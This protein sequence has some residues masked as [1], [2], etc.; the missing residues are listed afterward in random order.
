MA[1]Y[2]RNVVSLCGLKLSSIG[3]A[4]FMFSGGLYEY[5]A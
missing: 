3:F 5:V 2:R 1:A 4:T